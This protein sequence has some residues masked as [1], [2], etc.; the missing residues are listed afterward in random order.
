MLDPPQTPASTTFVRSVR[1]F[2]GSRFKRSVGEGYIEDFLLEDE[3]YNDI[4]ANF[5]SIAVGGAG[6]ERVSLLFGN[7]QVALLE[8][9]TF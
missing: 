4:D 3:N 1:N 2:G 9:R 5:S 7:R 8:R 6:D